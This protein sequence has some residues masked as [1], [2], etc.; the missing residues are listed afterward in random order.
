MNVGFT[1]IN[2][3]DS[4]SAASSDLRGLLILH[5]HNEL[6]VRTSHRHGLFL[7]TNFPHFRR[8]GIHTRTRPYAMRFFTSRPAREKLIHT[9]LRRSPELRKEARMGNSVECDFELGQG[10]L[11]KDE[12]RTRRS[13]ASCG[14]SA[15]TCPSKRFPSCLHRAVNQ[16]LL[17]SQ[18]LEYPS[19]IVYRST[20]ELEIRGLV[21]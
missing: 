5:H 8:S 13:V 12:G 7:Q 10:N 1:I 9:H 16:N 18:S 4:Y 11:A 14:R 15:R 19:T 2:H 17:T 6:T 3:R 20:R 21:M